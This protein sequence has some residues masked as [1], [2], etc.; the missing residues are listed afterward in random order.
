[1]VEE[2]SLDGPALARLDGLSKFVLGALG[3]VVGHGLPDFVGVASGLV[4]W[5][6]VEEMEEVGQRL[7][8]EGVSRLRA[9]VPAADELGPD[10]CRI[11]NIHLCAAGVDDHFLVTFSFL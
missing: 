1:M 6:G 3:P 10:V 4:V 2:G 7:E 11:A 5:I 9:V 8:A